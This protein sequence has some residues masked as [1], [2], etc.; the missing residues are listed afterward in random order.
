MYI[1]RI[2]LSLLLFS[3]YAYG[4]HAHSIRY[5]SACLSTEHRGNPDTI[6]ALI[7]K[8]KP[9]VPYNHVAATPTFLVE[10]KKDTF[11]AWRNSV[12]NSIEN[13][14]QE[15]ILEGNTTTIRSHI[16]SVHAAIDRLENQRNYLKNA[17]YADL[18]ENLIAV[19]EQD[20]VFL[21]QWAREIVIQGDEIVPLVGIVL[22]DNLR[23]ILGTCCGDLPFVVK[24]HIY[25]QRVI[26]AGWVAVDADPAG[27]IQPVLHPNIIGEKF[28]FYKTRFGIYFRE[29]LGADEVAPGDLIRIV[30]HLNNDP[31]NK[32]AVHGENAMI[33]WIKFPNDPLFDASLAGQYVP[34]K[35]A[36]TASWLY[37]QDFEALYTE[38]RQQ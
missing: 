11:Y 5:N 24:D 26:E 32:S 35:N 4:V 2:C 34:G 29:T 10:A 38:L 8:N 37:A 6:D 31:R 14:L 17:C 20:V 9:A 16:S 22:D 23:L 27:R 25:W 1:S 19:P 33:V 18:G 30:T 15:L 21:M 36:T 7:F 3:P 28:H 12:I 13:R